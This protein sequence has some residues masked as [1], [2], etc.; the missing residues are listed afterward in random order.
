VSC[1]G[2]CTNSESCTISWTSTG[3]TSA[4]LQLRRNGSV[5]DSVSV[6]T[7]GS[8]TGGGAGACFNQNSRCGDSLTLIV[9]GPG[10]SVS[11]T[12]T[13]SF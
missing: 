5:L 7:N 4:V 8:C 9:T 2:G 3:S 13:N 11:Q 1:G 6:P 10:G 12:I